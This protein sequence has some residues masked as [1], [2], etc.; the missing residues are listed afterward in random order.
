MS[1]LLYYAKA[2]VLVPEPSKVIHVPTAKAGS[3]GPMAR[4]PITTWRIRGVSR[5]RVLRFEPRMVLH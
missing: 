4:L 1:W 5:C 3:P 2:G